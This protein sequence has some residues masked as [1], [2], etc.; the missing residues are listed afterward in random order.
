M[1]SYESVVSYATYRIVLY[2]TSIVFDFIN[3]G[4]K[5]KRV[6]FLVSGTKS[7]A[8]LNNDPLS[9]CFGKGDWPLCS[10]PARIMYLKESHQ[11]H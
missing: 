2:C 10:S 1:V 3:I 6:M 11:K 7:P 5:D 4:A 8:K 9:T